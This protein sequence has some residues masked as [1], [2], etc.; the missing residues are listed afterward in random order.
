[1]DIAVAN[2][3]ITMYAKVGSIKEAE[4]VFSKI[5]SKNVVS[6]T[7]MIGGYAQ[8]GY[9]KEAITLFE[10]MN[11]FKVMPNRVTFV[12]LLTACSHAGLK[13]QAEM[14]FHSMEA[15]YGITPGIEH[16][17]CLVDVLGRA[18]RLKEAEELINR[19]PYESNALVWRMLL[20]ACRK[21]G[22]L[23]RGKRS[24]ERILALEPRDS[25]AYVLLSN[26]YA[27]Q[28]KW[29]GV[30]KIRKLMR[31]NGV[32]KEPGKS[33]IEIRNRIHEFVSGDHSH[34]QADGIYSKI[35][36]L[37]VEMKLAGYAPDIDYVLHNI[38]EEMKEE[39]V[40]YHSERLA[41]ALG[42]INLTPGTT[43][44]VFKN[45]RI[46]GDCHKAV[47]LISKIVGREIVVRDTTRFHHFK[48][49]LCSCSDY[50]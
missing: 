7:A 5:A 50:W 23:E 4:E 47:K 37:L 6:W 29:E 21:H 8:N 44:K 49:G 33:W 31:E 13:E 41:I 12:S 26:I 18:G 10:Q 35:N 39:F 42:L 24:A 15:E 43:I 46:C 16:Y 32:R 25:A 2:A 28:G 19:M 3:L 27:A 36:E 38:E 1:M 45:L 30:V 34:P 11:S 40:C 9:A 48:D 17:A 20:S 14:F 22:D